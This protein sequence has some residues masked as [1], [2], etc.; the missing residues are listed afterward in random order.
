MRKLAI[1]LC[2]L[3]LAWP[4]TCL[5]EETGILPALEQ[6]QTLHSHYDPDH[7]VS[8]SALTSI[9]TAAFSMPTGGGQRS[10]EFYVVQDRDTLSAM[11]GG[12]PWSQA[13]VT[14]PCVIVV[15]ADENRAVY[16]ELQEM[17]AGLA[18]GAIL[19]QATAEGLTTCVLSISPQQERIRSVRE[20]LGMSDTTTPILMIALGYPAADAVSSASVYG[21][22]GAQVHVVSASE[23]ENTVKLF[24]NGT[25]VPVTW[26]NNAS[27]EALKELLPLTVQMSM[28]G[29]FEQVGPIG[30]SI[31]RD[32]HQTTTQSGDIVLYSGNQIVVFYGSNSW[33]YTRLGHIDLSQQEMADLLSH[34]D[35]TITLTK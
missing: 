33:A 15:A 26:E 28:Y 20:A 21:W 24:I 10:L 9:L 31:T 16:P 34:G 25:E 12:N 3:L 19:A 5:A 13:L 29:G 2:A 14:C 22:N 8:E 27:V 4:F 6:R 1:V 17:D 7:M 30:Q 11:R 32:D 23:E 18:A 35:V